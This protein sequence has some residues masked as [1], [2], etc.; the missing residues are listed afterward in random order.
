MTRNG[1]KR[2]YAWVGDEGRDGDGDDETPGTGQGHR[3][4]DEAVRQLMA[5]AVL[6]GVTVYGLDE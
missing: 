3:R 2:L 5:I 6:C 4:D 1:D